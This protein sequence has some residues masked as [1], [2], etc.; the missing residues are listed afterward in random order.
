MSTALYD[1]VA[2][3]LEVDP[4]SLDDASTR[5]SIEGWD[6]LAHIT[7]ITTIEETYGVVLSTEEVLEATSLGQIRRLLLAK[8]A[9]V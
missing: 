8:G 7:L 9:P 2:D 4:S 6:S 3:V 5:T 1:L